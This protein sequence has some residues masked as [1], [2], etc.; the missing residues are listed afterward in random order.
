MKFIRIRFN[1]KS[2]LL[3]ITLVLILGVSC[4]SFALFQNTESDQSYTEFT[5]EIEDAEN[6]DELV[7]ADLEIENTNIRTVTN[8]E[9][10]FLLKIPNEYLDRNLI[11]SYLGFEKLT[12]KI[13]ELK[14]EDNKFSLTRLVTNLGEVN[15]NIPK[16]A[17]EIVTEMLKRKDINYLNQSTLMTA[18]YRETIKKRR[19]NASLA[20]AVVD[21]Y[22]QPYNSDRTDKVIL[23]KSRKSTNYSK[24]DTIALKL[25]GGPF[26]T[27]YSDLIK[28]QEFVFSDDFLDVYDFKMENSTRIDNRLVYVISFKQKPQILSPLY[29]GK[30][31]VDAATYALNSAI[32][33]LNVENEELAANLFVQRKPRRVSVFPTEAKYRVDY[34]N[35][36][37]KWYYGYSNI[38]LTFKVDWKGKLFN[39]VYTL[40]SEMVITDWEMNSTDTNKVKNQLR[41][42]V[43]L[44]DE[45][46]GFQDPEFWG[47][48]NII[49]PEKSIEQAIRKINR[50]T[51]RSK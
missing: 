44:A 48:Y 8:T 17:G 7:F 25:Q 5:G 36:D 2:Q 14:K 28:Y 32:Y 37:G 51:D 13:S 42:S 3:L 22:K 19:Q 39:S 12:V 4:Q 26:N 24:L 47:E 23:L 35:K 9:G 43:I 10:E 50:Q 18:F 15:I 16:S 6:G 46:S 30:I 20:E 45:A 41:P 31:Y 40:N 33:D 38:Q 49:E 34:K 1:I 11:I 21:V 29:F 27:L